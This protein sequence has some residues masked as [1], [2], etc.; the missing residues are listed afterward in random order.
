M[1][2]PLLQTKL[3]I[4][5][6]RS[7]LVQR[8]RIVAKMNE[9]LERRLILVSAPAGFGKSTMLIEW[10]RTTGNKVTWLS[11]DES[12][13]DLKRFF[14]YL[15][16][17][18]QKIN[19]SLGQDVLP[20][21]QA[22]DNPQMEHLLTILINDITEV[23]ED[24]TLI[25]DDYHLIDNQ[26]THNGLKFLIDHVPP[27]MHLVI[28]SR[29]DPPIPLTR[30]RAR[31]QVTEI[32]SRDLRFNEAE[33]EAFLNEQM[34]LNLATEDISALHKRT[35]GWITGLH[36]AALSMQNRDD[37]HD[38]IT[39]FSGGHHYIIDYLVSEV[40]SQQPE[41]IQNFLL[42]S[43]FLDRFCATLCD[44]ALEISNSKIIIQ[45][46]NQTNL[47]LISLDDERNWYR[48]HHLFANFLN[49]RLREKEA[50]SIPELHQ[51]ASK[52]LEQNHYFPEAVNH[53]LAGEDYEHAAQ[54][55]EKLGP[56][57]MMQNEFDQLS[58]WL[59]AMPENFVES[60]PWLCIIRAWMYDRWG[61]Y[62]DGERYLQHAE[63]ALERSAT[64]TPIEAERI[65]RGQISA[66]R[67]LY[68]LK[69]A[70][71]SQSIE[72][73][74]QAL[75]Y[76]PKDYFNRGVASFSLGWAKNVLGDLSG[77]IQAF[78]EGRRAS[79][80][81]R[82][83]ILA[84]AIILYIG[85]T[86]F[87]QG[88]LHQAAET[89]REVNQFK[90]EKSNIKIPYASS[91]CIGLAHIHREW[92]EL[93][94]AMNYI[95]EGIEIG[96]ASRVVDAITL[97][98][99]TKALL[100][101]D[102]GDIKA[103]NEAYENAEQMV[104]DTQNL[105]AE[106]LSKTLDSR[107]RLLLAEDQLAAAS[108]HVQEAGLG[109]DVEIDNYLDIP[110]IILAR[111]LIRSGR[112]NS[113]SQDLSDAHKVLEKILEVTRPAGY[114]GQVIGALVLQALAFEAQGIRDQA[115][116]S[117]EEALT[118]A[119]SEGYIRT[120]VDEGAPMQALLQQVGTKGSMGAYVSMLLKAFEPQDTEATHAA[121][122]KLIEPL[123]ERELEVL[124]M[125]ATELSGPEIAHALVISLNTLRTHTKNIY[126]KLDVGKRRSAVRVARELELI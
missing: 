44:A 35:E 126:A 114:L 76:L 77:A 40:L 18:I 89:L 69:T 1:T 86:Q 21:L 98:Y 51:R 55:I 79:L 42:Q 103:A 116:N 59:D 2:T 8:L 75:D 73:S 38:F 32:R 28:A 25:L 14:I 29:V 104:E 110:L 9:G 6:P 46:L 96:I 56:D 118:L 67:A 60:W 23:N 61:R 83:R 122:Q 66:L 65:I 3:F 115:L 50:K 124:K 121:D 52:W 12:D 94:A 99:A 34:G 93:D 91:A 31:D 22:A 119:E 123:S 11:I 72:Y 82:N 43:S 105:E 111:V 68:A 95:Q 80:A 125:L 78:E 74:N 39:A 16:F 84:Q 58:Q 10:A 85:K 112:Q 7:G 19:P 109:L 54:L 5:Q 113:A 48:Y 36:L 108:R 15:I 26:D 120:F 47:F 71:I 64:S 49:Q 102:Q 30:L 13:N 117:L 87:I 37:K 57:M 70:Q 107:V 81:A 53:S 33:A 101:L 100:C 88:H 90:Y 97:G 24:F 17:A 62:D 106:T 27:N 63:S 4:P 41:E 45:T 20:V 92:N